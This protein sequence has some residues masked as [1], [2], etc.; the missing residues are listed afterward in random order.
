MK[1]PPAK[2]KKRNG[3]KGKPVA[4]ALCIAAT[5]I[6]VIATVLLKRHSAE[7]NV[8]DRFVPR[9]RGE[10]TFNKHIAPI[11]FQHCAG[12]HRPGEAGP[13]SLLTYQQVKAK[14]KDVVKVTANRYMPPWLP[15]HGGPALADERRLTEDEIGVIR[16][17]SE[18]GAVE[19]LAADLPPLPR[20]T[21]GWQLGT[22]D[23]VAEMPGAYTL[24]T[25]GRDVYRN[26]VIPLSVPTRR[27]VR[28]ME[29]KP[30]SKVFHHIFVR[31][32]RTRQSRRLDAQ[33]AEAGFG[34]MAVPPTAETPGGHF[35][36]WQPGRGPARSPDGLAWALEPNSDLILLAHLQ[37]NG[38]PETVRPSIGFYFTDQAPTNSAF[39]IVLSSM[40]IDIPAGATNYET[41][42]SYV[43]PVDAQVLAVLPHAHYLGKEMHGT[44]VLPN[45]ETRSLLSIKEWDFNWQSDY[46]Y[47]EPIQLPKG[48]RIGMLF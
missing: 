33:D 3:Q 21:E 29:F 22:P 26:F 8:A 13:F 20:W 44:A 46:R 24:P 12:C 16:Q 6:A 34:G 43:L 45:G 30:N 42:D 18:E 19:G 7:S 4:A 10:L 36:S 5:A 38:K 31:F 2:P 25:E 37:P 9:P 1:H 41:Q 48:T 32:D 14:A 15:E 40:D 17:W 39:K 28:A 11:L 35:L 27:F 47:L 23:L